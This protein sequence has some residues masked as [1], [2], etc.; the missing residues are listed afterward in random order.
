MP[1][2]VAGPT[3]APLR[4]EA[5]DDGAVIAGE[6]NGFVGEVGGTDTVVVVVV[7]VVAT[8]AWPAGLGWSK[9]VDQADPP[10]RAPSCDETTPSM[11][12]VPYSPFGSAAIRC[13]LPYGETMLSVFSTPCIV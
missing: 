10:G 1:T 6:V 3:E 5:E 2:G 13:P 8:P 4:T 7:I 9:W 11:L 12:A